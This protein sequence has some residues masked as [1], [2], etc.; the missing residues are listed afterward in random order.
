MHNEWHMFTQL[1]AALDGLVAKAT[2]HHAQALNSDLLHPPQHRLITN[3]FMELVDIISQWSLATVVNCGLV[4][5][6]TI[7]PPGFSLPR[8]QWCALNRFRRNHGHFGAC[9]K[10]CGLADSDLWV[11]GAT[12]TTS[13]IVESCPLM[14]LDGGLKKLHT[15]DNESVGWRSSYNT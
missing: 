4:Q 12:Q 8:K 13:H 7:Y 6:P 5:D 11:C 10:L 14:K 15:A 1:L 2:V 9:R 3:S